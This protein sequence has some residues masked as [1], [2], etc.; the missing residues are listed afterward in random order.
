[1][2]DS[3]EVKTFVLRNTELGFFINARRSKETLTLIN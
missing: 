1:M 3:F 2:I